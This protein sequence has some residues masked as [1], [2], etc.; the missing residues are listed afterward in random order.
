MAY[1]ALVQ[2]KI[3]P[4]SDVGHRRSILTEFVVPEVST[5]RGFKSAIWLNDGAGTGTCVAQFETQEDA[6]RALE[7]LA[8][9]NGPD[10]IHV[11]T[12][13]VELEA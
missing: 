12:C 11:G 1:A 10:V 13:E 4:R 7:V 8:P 2:V 3:E 9:S 6:E 5:L